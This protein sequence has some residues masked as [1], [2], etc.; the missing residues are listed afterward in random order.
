MVVRTPTAV[1]G[2]FS[3]QIAAEDGDVV[4]LVVEDQAGNRSDAAPVTVVEIDVRPPS[5]SS[6]TPA[7]GTS[8]VVLGTTVRVVFD[9]DISPTPDLQALVSL[10][11][12]AGAIAGTVALESNSV[13]VFTPSAPLS[14]D[15]RHTVRVAGAIDTSGNVQVGTFTSTFDTPD[16]TA[17]TLG[18]STVAEGQWFTTARPSLR[19]T[20]SDALSGV[21]TSTGVM[22][23][24]SAPVTV[25]FG[26]SSATF[27]P[28]TDLSEGL[29]DISASI[30]DASGNAS[31]VN[32]GFGVDTV[33]PAVP[34]FTGVADGAQVSGSFTAT[35]VTNDATSGLASVALTRDGG[36]DEGSLDPNVS[37]EKTF[38]VSGV[39]EGEHTYTAV[40]ADVAG[41]ASAESAVLTV[42]VDNVPLSVGFASPAAGTPFNNSVTVTAI[43]SEDV[44]QIQFTAGGASVVDTEA[45]YEA[46]F[47]VSSEPDGDYVITATGTDAFGGTANDQLTV[48]VDRTPPAA[49]VGALIQANEIEVGQTLVA[50]DPGS[51]ESS[52]EIEAT[53]TRDAATATITARADGS[54]ALDI[55]GIKDDTIELVAVDAAG[56]RSVPTAVPVLRNTT[57]QGVPLDGLR[58]W[59]RA[60]EGI[61]TDANGNVSHWDDQSNS[62][63]DMSQGAEPLRPTFVADGINGRPSLRYD[64]TDDVLWFTSRIS[65]IRTV[66]WVLRE[67]PEATEDYHFVLGDSVYADFHG[68]RNSIWGSSNSSVAVRNGLTWLNGEL[69]NGTTTERPTVASVLSVITQGSVRANNLSKDRS[70]ARYWWGDVGEVIIYDRPLTDDERQSVEDYL[71]AKFQIEM[72]GGLPRVGTPR[73]APNGGTFTG[74]SPLRMETTTPG[75]VVHYTLDGSEPTEASPAYQQE[76]TL[77]ETTRVRARAYRPGF[78]PSDETTVEFVNDAEDF[79]PSSIPGMAA[80]LTTSAGIPPSRD[81]RFW[82]D[83]SGNNNYLSTNDTRHGPKIVRDGLN[84]FPVLRYDGVDD[85]LWFRARLSTIRTVFWVLKEADEAPLGQYRFLLGDSGLPRLPRGLKHSLGLLELEHGRSQRAHG[86][87]RNRGR[88]HADRSTE[89]CVGRVARDRREPARQQSFPRPVQRGSGLVG[90]RR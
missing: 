87:Q 84:G 26:G 64:G 39:S 23:V 33:A 50:G 57:F 5:V 70:G 3:L 4:N 76:L 15:V 89:D 7:N 42:I 90:R 21:D 27:N 2:S 38:D 34:S 1:D 37:L 44:T 81:M 74:S 62:N 10:D 13:A 30:S 16:T 85:Q 25:S 66:F 52:H 19:A 40:A 12:A 78:A 36:F 24:D 31:S 65:N 88:W 68:G 6:V 56:N 80:W 17:P 20:Y 72:D 73:I 58:M 14:T 71:V 77:T 45:P 67:A 61:T 8:E 60:D 55:S 11:G 47:D 41:N 28:G 86:D 51:V 53:N 63:N 46:T 32:V 79:V 82:P 29:H 9:E 43:P 18:F 22:T 75:A 69:I 49:P 35:L 54:F 83:Q 48:V 59:L